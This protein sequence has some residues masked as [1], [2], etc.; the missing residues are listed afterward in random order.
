MSVAIY[1]KISP[2]EKRILHGLRPFLV[3]LYLLVLR[4]YM[5][6]GTGIVG[7]K[8]RLSIVAI[9]EEM[10]VERHMGLSREE[11][12][13]PHRNKV[14]RALDQLITVGL[15]EPISKEKPLVFRCVFAE[16][17]QSV[18]KQVGHKVGHQV[19]HSPIPENPIPIES[20]DDFSLQVGHQAGHQV[21]TP[22]VKDIFIKKEKINKKEKREAA[23]LELPFWLE[24]EVWNKFVD[25]RTQIRKPLTHEA[26]RLSIKKLVELKGEGYNP[27]DVIDQSIMNRWT[28][29]FPV[30]GDHNHVKPMFKPA[31]A[32]AIDNILQSTLGVEYDGLKLDK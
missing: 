11:S 26:I 6:Y 18:Q 2:A 32:R 3:K 22:P 23:P 1:T 12:G 15:I 29:L 13:K 9:Q 30:K 20:P 21:G 8:R 16:R 24:K 25:Y 17:D 7:L 5:D 10:Y 14:R 27:I 31:A 28:G 4:E 19:G